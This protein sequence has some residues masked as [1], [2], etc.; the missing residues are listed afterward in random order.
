MEVLL[1]EALDNVTV[2]DWST[3]VKHAEKLQKYYEKECVRVNIIENITINLEDTD[4]EVTDNN[5]QN[6]NFD[7]DDEPL[8]V[9]LQEEHDEESAKLGEIMKDNVYSF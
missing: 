7:Y 4:D 6:Y 3:R 2:E 1:N 8:A 5:F 9:P